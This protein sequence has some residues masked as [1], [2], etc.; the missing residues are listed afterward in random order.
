LIDPS[1]LVHSIEVVLSR[2]GRKEMDSGSQEH[3]EEVFVGNSV[4]IAISHLE[5][6]LAKE[7]EEVLARLL[8]PHTVTSR[9]VV[10]VV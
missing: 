1:N 4:E 5:I 9:M 7:S 6:G 10:G 2:H 8:S 3:L